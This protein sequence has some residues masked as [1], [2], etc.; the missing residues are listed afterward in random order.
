MWARS[1]ALEDAVEA[2][3]R[4]RVDEGPPLL[5]PRG[6]VLAAGSDAA[7]GYE[8]APV[9]GASGYRV[10]VLRHDGDLDDAKVRFLSGLVEKMVTERGQ[11]GLPRG[12]V[13]QAVDQMDLLDDAGLK[14]KVQRYVEYILAHQ[15]E[16]GWLGPREMI[17]ASGRPASAHYDLWAQLL[18]AKVLTQYYDATEDLRAMEALLKNLHMIDRHIDRAPLFNWAQFRW[19][20]ALIAIYRAFEI[21]GEGWLLD[22][23]TKLHAQ[24]FH[25]STFFERWPMVEPTTKGRWNYMGHVVNNAMA[26]KA[27]GLWYR[28]SQDEQDWRAVQEQIDKLDQYHGMVTGMFTGDECLAGRRPTQGT[29]LCAVVEYAFSLEVLSAITGDPAF[30]DRLERII[31]NAVGGRNASV[32]CRSTINRT[33]ACGSKSM[34]AVSTVIRSRLVGSSPTVSRS[35]PRCAWSSPARTT[36]RC[37]W[38]WPMSTCR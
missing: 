19:F 21:T 5:F 4:E 2:V 27:H 13:G 7:Q 28:L 24:G 26:V 22:L 15:G 34:S 1:R 10:D 20:E 36:G 8:L 11:P 23:A 32:T 6:R 12:N 31:F 18:A 9:A 3:W 35:R 37:W 38:G 29:E 25:W 33:A 16:D 30:A 14:A 17:A